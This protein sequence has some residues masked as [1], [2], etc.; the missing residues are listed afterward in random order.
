MY[1]FFSFILPSIYPRET[2]YSR[3]LFPGDLRP[4]TGIY[5]HHVTSFKYSNKSEK[6]I[7]LL[8]R[9]LTNDIYCFWIIGRM[10]NITRGPIKWG[11]LKC[12]LWRL[13]RSEAFFLLNW[14]VS[15]LVTDRFFTYF[16]HYRIILSISNLAW[17]FPEQ[18]GKI[19]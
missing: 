3:Y 16:R 7:H 18:L 17:W 1:I 11:G 10:T 2:K 14:S 5:T 15:P 13:F 9:E 12:V 6:L 19:K 8:P 4:I